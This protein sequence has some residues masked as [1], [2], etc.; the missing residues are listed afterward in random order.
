ML[1]NFNI[2]PVNNVFILDG[3]INHDPRYLPEP[4]N[5]NY[6][7]ISTTLAQGMSLLSNYVCMFM[8]VFTPMTMKEFRLKKVN[9]C[10]DVNIVQPSSTEM[11]ENGFAKFMGE[12]S[13]PL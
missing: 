10:C 6:T 4:H 11:R 12:L 2:L 1:K 8:L 13:S 3:A 9:E 5:Y 7:T